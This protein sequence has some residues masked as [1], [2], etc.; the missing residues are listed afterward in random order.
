MERSGND[1]RCTIMFSHHRLR[2]SL[3]MWPSTLRTW[4]SSSDVR[5][6]WPTKPE[7]KTTCSFCHVFS[8][9]QHHRPM[10]VAEALICRHGWSF[11]FG[12]M[13]SS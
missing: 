3:T 6:R 5:L 9:T 10:L 13:L 1:N 2:L 7:S 8:I 4:V 11:M 12:I